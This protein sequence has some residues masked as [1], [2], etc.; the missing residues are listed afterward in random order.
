MLAPETRRLLTDALRPP[1]GFSLD[2]AVATTYSLNL[3]SLLMAPLAMAAHDVIGGADDNAGPDPI[4]LL[5]AVRRHAGRTTVFCQAGGVHVPG[6]YRPMLGFIEDSVVQVVPQRDDRVFHP[7]IWALRFRGAKG[8]VRHRFLCLSRNLTMDRSWDTVV[9]LEESADEQGV[10]TDPL[11]AFLRDLPGLTSQLDDERREQIDDLAGTLARVRLD[12]PDPFSDGTL[13]PLG[14]ASS[15]RAPRPETADRLVVISPFLDAGFLR[16]LPRVGAD[17]RLVSRGETFDRVGGQAV[18]SGM[19]T[20]VLQRAAETLDQD[21]EAVPDG[22]RAHVELST[23]LHAKT[24]VWD[25][26][27]TGH[28]LTGSANATTPAFDGNVEFNLL[29]RG[30]V[31]SCGTRALVA[32]GS[33]TGEVGLTRLL[34]PYAI[35][36]PEP[37]QD[38][39]FEA[40]KALE[41]FHARLA[42]AGLRLVAV[43]DAHGSYTVSL[44]WPEVAAPPQSS[45]MVRLLGREGHG[46]RL[47]D[48]LTWNA[49]AAP[50]LSPFV[51]LETRLLADP[52]EVSRSCVVKG[53]LVGGPED[54]QRQILRELLSNEKDLLRYLALLFGDATFESLVA[55]LGDQV[56]DGDAGRS[57]PSV[58]A[59]DLVVFEPMI[60]AAARR[61]GSL[62]RVDSLLTELTG[63]DG[64]IPHLSPAFMSLWTTVWAA[65]KE[66]Q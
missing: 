57:G 10:D 43:E 53:E 28:V 50:R 20:W 65:A 32:D 58:T 16:R 54:R 30:P 24:F 22:T 8:D 51:V 42:M 6:R 44:E 29:L 46:L 47:G 39:A 40:E 26:G 64:R 3:T 5:E 59:D 25:E 11:A 33:D 9:Q 66:L 49:V 18:P 62:A 37:S 12:V 36:S 34:Q 4:A 35:I 17:A 60:R 45:T 61:D 38:P 63:S 23:G 55:G 14:T 15:G 7:K 13:V 1:T 27:R 41:Q 2:L 56:T 52:S 21:D 19:T 31:R 48:P